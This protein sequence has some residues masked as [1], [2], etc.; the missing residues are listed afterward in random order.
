[1]LD[2]FVNQGEWWTV[3][4]IYEYS[5]FTSEYSL[6]IY[7]YLLFIFEYSEILLFRKLHSSIMNHQEWFT[8]IEEDPNWI[9]IFRDDFKCY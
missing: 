1:M 5:L 4:I 8:E 7:E 6:S 9:T 2:I 3:A